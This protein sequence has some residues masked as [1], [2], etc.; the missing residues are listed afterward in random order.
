MSWIRMTVVGA[1]LCA[2]ASVAEAQRP[3][4]G[5][6]TPGSGMGGGAGRGRMQAMLFEGITLTA[7]QQTQIRAITEKAAKDRKD[8]MPAGGMGGAPDPAMRKMMTEM[9]AKHHS[10]MRAVLTADQQK[11]FDT[12]VAAMQ[13]RRQKRMARPP[14][15]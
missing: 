8:H 12:N 5:G 1:A 10:D 9:Q 13:A 4:A 3:P 14:Q 6:A 11:V 15:P 7:A 2:A